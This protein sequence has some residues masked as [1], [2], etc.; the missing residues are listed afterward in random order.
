MEYQKFGRYEVK[1]VLGRGGMAVV[2]LAY[3]PTISREVAI[4]ILSSHLMDDPE[5]RVKLDQEVHTVA[6]LEHPCIVPV[7]DYGEENGQPYVV[8]RY[9]TGGSLLSRIKAG[10]LPPHELAQIISRVARALDVAHSHHIIHRDI[11]PGNLLF[12]DQ[13]Q[14]YLSDFGIAKVVEDSATKTGVTTIGTPAYMSP[15]QGGAAKTIDGRSDIYSLGI[16]IFEALTGQLPYQAETPVGLIMQHISQEI[17]SVVALRPDLS[18]DYDLVIRQAM[19]KTPDQRYPTASALAAD[20]AKIVQGERVWPGLA[21]ENATESAIETLAGQNLS[22]IQPGPDSGEKWWQRRATRFSA[23]LGAGLLVIVAISTMLLNGGTSPSPVTP[24]ITT[25]VEPVAGSLPTPSPT[26]TSTPIPPTP[27]SMMAG[28][29]NSRSAKLYAGPGEQYAALATLPGET[30]FA[31]LGRNG[32][33]DWLKI[34]SATGKEGWISTAQTEVFMEILDVPLVAEPTATAS[35]T[36]R[37][38]ATATATDT[39]T[40]SPTP[41]PA[42]ACSSEPRGDFANLWAKYK[43]RLKCPHQTTPID[44][45]FAEQPFQN[46]HMFWAE[47]AELF[48][49][50]LGSSQGTWQLIPEDDSIWKE[51][52]PQKSCDLPIPDGLYQPVRGFGGIWCDNSDIRN[53]IGWALA[54]ER[55]FKDGIDLIQGFEGGVIFRDSDGYS[56]KLAYVLFWDDNSFVREAY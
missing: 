21:L 36:P 11:K 37:P 27:R 41:V 1:R 32:Q 55:G 52:M 33:G 29:V 13:Q 51:G 15:E 43:S 49:I 26:A 56:N 18:P 53:Q 42:V 9:M 48:L 38:Q 28:V 45:F 22:S 34:T 50:T 16:V 4:K 23:L 2:H 14:A 30:D 31:L 54:D 3:D 8:M 17:P 5:F 46:G 6:R 24:A 20:L 10:P 39:P 12:D 40:P 44:G 7:Y 19:A 47:D 35:P 25:A